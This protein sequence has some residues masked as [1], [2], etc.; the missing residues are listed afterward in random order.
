MFMMVSQS[1]QMLLFLVE[2]APS[3]N[4]PRS[5]SIFERYA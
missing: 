5:N 4:V 1:I 3:I 2:C